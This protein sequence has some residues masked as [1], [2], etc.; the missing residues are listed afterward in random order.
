MRLH[1]EEAVYQGIVSLALKERDGEEL[2]LGLRHLARVGIQVMNVEPIFAPLVA[3]GS[4]RLSDLVGVVGE[5]IVN[6]ATVDIEV[7]AHE[8]RGDAGA[9]NVPAGIS[10]SPRGSPL[11]LLV[12]K[13]GLG[14][15]ENEVSLVS[16]ILVCLNA[17]T[18]AYLKVLFLEIVENVILLKLR[19]VEIYVSACL[20][21]VSLLEKG[22]YHSDKLG[23]A[24]G[25]RL[26]VLGTLDVKLV[27]V[28]K[29]CVCI[30]LCNLKDG[31]VLT[32]CALQHLVLARV[33]VA[34]EMSDV[35]N[36]HYSR[37]VVTDVTE[38]FLKHV[39]HCIGTEV[40]D[41]C[42]MINR[43]AAGIH[44]YLACLS[45]NKFLSFSRCAVV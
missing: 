11:Q 12:V 33:A 15:P 31:L 43:G 29:K 21:G 6:T 5:G 20:V 39:L 4:L 18:H 24:V 19:G 25:G 40:A 30:V 22:L 17:V 41:V 34:G 37:H 26:N 27:A 9:L 35:G 1:A 2:A 28:S 45:G 10:D 7:L 23:N 44:R 14:E 13:L 36:V 8:F 42:K 3:E 38:I 16:L 32:L